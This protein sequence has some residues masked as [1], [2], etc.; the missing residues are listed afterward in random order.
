[1][2]LYQREPREIRRIAII[3][4]SALGDVCRSVPVLVSLRRHFPNAEIDWIVQDTFVDAIRAHPDLHEAIPFARDR[5]SR[6]GRDWGATRALFEWVKDLRRRKYDVVYDCQGLARSAFISWSTRAPKRVGF[7]DAREAAHLAYTHPYRVPSGLHTVD[8]MLAL[9]REDGIE[10]IDDMRLYTPDDAAAW[11]VDRR[12]ELSMPLD[13]SYAVLAP[14]SRWP[15]KQWPADRF[16]ALPA[17]ILERGIEHVVV[18]GAASE[19]A[20][21]QP[22]LDVCDGRQVI[23][24][25]GETT[26]GS[27]MGVIEHASLVVAND[28]AAVHIAAGFRRKA[29]ALFGPTNVDAVGPYPPGC[30][31]VLQHL[32]LDEQVSHKDP[33]L[34]ARIMERISLDE[35]LRVLDGL[36]SDQEAACPP[37]TAEG[38]ADPNGE[39]A[40]KLA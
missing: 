32:N 37:P 4:P 34:K 6:T 19:R 17:A 24:L 22:V 28:S 38:H 18:V 15:A 11:W 1:M 40:P 16:A 14:T 27:L 36:L 25:V 12:R 5:F 21:C 2:L 8:H 30:M 13:A 10:P 20:Q 9:L 39:T 29:I 26:V 7:A 33:D 35:I 31:T 3:R 23:D